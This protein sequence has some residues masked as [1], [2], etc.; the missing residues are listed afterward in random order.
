MKIKFSFPVFFITVIIL[1]IS[2]YFLIVG[3]ANWK[4]NKE[5]ALYAG[6]ESCR[7]CHEN[8]YQLWAPSHHGLAMQRV[9][10][11]F[12]SDELEIPE[13]R[14]DIGESVFEI[15]TDDNTLSFR[16]ITFLGDTSIYT[17][18]H[19]MGGKY[20]YYF[21]TEFERGRLHV[22]PVAY[23]CKENIWYNNPMSG[24]RH[25]ENMED[26]PLDWKN[27]LYTFN[28]ACYN[29]HVSQ[30]ESNFNLETLEYTTIW[31][32]NG[33]NCETCHGPSLEHI[34]V[35]V[36]AGEG[37]VPDDLKI[38]RVSEF[39]QE[40]NNASCGSCH[41]KTSVIAAGFNP[42][43]RY[44][45]YFD[46]ICLEH[47]D[48]YPD[49]RDLGENYTMTTWGMNKC[50]T[51]GQLD[52]VT[53][54]TSSGRYLFASENKNGACAPC[55]NDKIENP[56]AHTFHKEDGEGGLCISCHMPMTTFARMD[57]SDHSFRPPMPDATIEFG[58][59]NAC[60]ICHSD[61]SPQWASEDIRIKHKREYQEE[62]I[63]AGR[64]IREA[65]S[66]NWQNLDAII[67]GLSDNN[68][69][70]IFTTSFIRLLEFCD[71][72]RKWDA[73][74]EKTIDPSP[75]VRSSAAHALFTNIGEDAY[76]TLLKMIEDEYRLVRLNAAFALSNNPRALSS[77][78]DNQLLRDALE[79][80]RNSLVSRNDDWTAYYNLGNY[81]SNFGDHS[82]ALEAYLNSIRVYPEAIMPMVNAGYIYSI[83]G[84]MANAEKMFELA[85]SYSPE[86]EAILLNLALLFGETGREG[87]AIDYL[88]RLLSVSENNTIAAYNLSVLLADEDKDESLR[89]IKEA[90]R[91]EGD[92]VKYAYTYAF[93]LS[94]NQDFTEARIVLKKLISSNPAYQDAI[95]LL[96]DIEV[97][98]GNSQVA[99]E[100]L[101]NGIDSDLFGEAEK[102]RFANILSLINDTI[103]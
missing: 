46:L 90:Y 14:V 84:D 21:L 79:E 62:T 37:N 103:R 7:P 75:L 38:I 25:F 76:N 24:V 58:S 8:F 101:K 36:K 44:Y 5:V 49:G 45:D 78:N 15:S 53:C 56:T 65:R 82:N 83:A 50:K 77:L 41:G 43:D 63:I 98:T 33:I 52:C 39:S 18:V 96:S 86:N 55:H 81:Y 60:N 6:S 70:P 42:G 93:F 30:L 102:L 69:D 16:E 31:R 100:I 34:E 35:C 97:Q 3:T 51:G 11:E 87:L 48:F 54:H 95:I 88:K 94:N 4:F 12:I 10:A 80:Y 68:F 66:G 26:G 1:S 57:R 74:F 73:I 67:K 22:L 91:L 40:Q 20:I 89:L 32:E 29:C 9:S 19:V 2:A 13:A 85:L 99:R 59:P 61:K 71:D 28:T 27:H 64:L 17:A 23:D 72:D 47:Q 92:N